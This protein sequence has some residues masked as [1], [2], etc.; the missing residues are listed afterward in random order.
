MLL[1][2]DDVHVAG[3]FLGN[4]TKTSPQNLQTVETMSSWRRSS[5]QEKKLRLP[6]VFMPVGHKS[7]VAF[8]RSLPSLIP[9]LTVSDTI[10]PTIIAFYQ[11][12]MRRQLVSR[13]GII[14]VHAVGISYDPPDK[15]TNVVELIDDVLS[16]P[17]GLLNPEN[18][19]H[20]AGPA[21]RQ[22]RRGGRWRRRGR[23][24]APAARF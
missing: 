15:K 5:A 18:T 11:E 2:G 24:A 12:L 17:A 20:L 1:I 3:L 22:W 10:P 9:Q 7:D 19:R 6:S 23:A 14:P 13:V 8:W 16:L 21:V 4:G